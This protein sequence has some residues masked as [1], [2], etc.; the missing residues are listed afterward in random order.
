M[1]EGYG[2]FM[3]NPAGPHAWKFDGQE[4]TL[5]RKVSVDSSWE[6]HGK[7]ASNNPA[8]QKKNTTMEASW[9]MHGNLMQNRGNCL[10]KFM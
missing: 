5:S 7:Q 8:I 10:G 1:W 6:F 3:E 2:N 9:K 4:W